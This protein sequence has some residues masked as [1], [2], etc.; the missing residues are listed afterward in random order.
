MLAV[1]TRIMLRH[2]VDRYPHFI[3]AAGSVGTVSDASDGVVCVRMREHLPGAEHWDN[4]VLWSVRDG[5]DPMLDVAILCKR[6]DCTRI[7]ASCGHGYCTDHQGD[8]WL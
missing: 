7:P 8:F 4:E 6:D 2:D 5:D 3:A 1:G